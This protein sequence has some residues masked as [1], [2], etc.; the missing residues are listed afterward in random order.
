MKMNHSDIMTTEDEL[1]EIETK[2]TETGQPTLEDSLDEEE[3]RLKLLNNRNHQTNHQ[4]CLR[5]GSSRL[6]STLDWHTTAN[7][8]SAFSRLAAE[9]SLIGDYSNAE[10][11]YQHAIFLS[12]AAMDE[13]DTSTSISSSLYN[14]GNGLNMLGGFG[15]AIA[16]L[17][18]KLAATQS[19][20][21]PSY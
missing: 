4:S 5:D 17:D 12:K 14:S 9:Y 1:D 3:R 13:V 7:M 19:K 15:T 16:N 10:A 8:A 6:L 20:V 21:T 11:L 18:Q 2:N